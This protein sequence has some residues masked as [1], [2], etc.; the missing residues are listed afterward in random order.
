MRNIHKMCAETA[1]NFGFEGNYVIGGNIAG[2]K[3]VADAMI[4]Q[5]LV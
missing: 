1:K 2:F 5:G 3:K 4:A